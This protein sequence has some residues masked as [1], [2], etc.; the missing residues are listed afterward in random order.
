MGQGGFG[1]RRRFLSRERQRAGR[2]GI[3]C[4]SCRR[5]DAEGRF[6][7]PAAAAWRLDPYSLNGEADVVVDPDKPRDIHLRRGSLTAEV[8][9]QNPGQP[10]VLVTPTARIEVLGTV[11]SV[12]ADA[13]RTR[14]HVDSGKVK[15]TRLVDGRSIEISGHESCL[16]SLNTNESL[17]PIPA[18]RSRPGFVH[19]FSSPPPG[20]WKGAWLE[21]SPGVPGRFAAVPCIMGQRLDG[22]MQPVIHYGI[23]LRPSQGIDL[24][25]L[26][27]NASF[28]LIYRVQKPHTFYSDDLRAFSRRTLCRKL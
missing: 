3:H 8:Q 1:D 24:G 4:D 13:E 22:D 6:C 17:G 16:A 10:L 19:T 25:A 2:R 14:V 23:T 15:V 7:C 5:A 26:P 18:G 21:A 28:G 20:R 12:L 11:L 27:E 9:R